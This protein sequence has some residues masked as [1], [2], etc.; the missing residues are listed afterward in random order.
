MFEEDTHTHI[1]WRGPISL[2]FV[3]SPGGISICV[4]IPAVA[5]LLREKGLFLKLAVETQLRDAAVL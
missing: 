5:F 2:E 1:G 3:C 4:V